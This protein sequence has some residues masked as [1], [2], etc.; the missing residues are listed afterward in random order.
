MI[1]RSLVNIYSEDGRP[2]ITSSNTVGETMW[3]SADE[4]IIAE[5]FVAPLPQVWRIETAQRETAMNF[6]LRNMLR[7]FAL[8]LKQ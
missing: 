4:I 1:Y 6:L 3:Y 2:L 7:A 8:L 5:L